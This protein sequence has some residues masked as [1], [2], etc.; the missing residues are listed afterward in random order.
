MLDGTIPK[1]ADIASIKGIST[2]LALPM[3]CVAYFLQ[4]GDS[5][6]LGEFVW[7]NPDEM[8]ST[9]ITLVQL[10][11]VFVLRSIW[12]SFI[13]VIIYGGLTQIYIRVN[14]PLVQL[15]SVLMI[16]F[17]LFGIFCSPQFPQLKSIN[18]FWFYGFAVWGIFLQA[19]KEQLDEQRQKI[20]AELKKKTSYRLG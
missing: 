1:I 6:T 11:I 9:Q 8:L 17:S 3:L 10:I 16:A 15:V 4:T 2:I 19:M 7:P 20:E 13:G 5:I 14:F 18:P 12:V